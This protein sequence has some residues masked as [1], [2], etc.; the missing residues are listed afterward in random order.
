[1]KCIMKANVMDN[2]HRLLAMTDQGASRLENEQ[3]RQAV[4]S[5]IW[6]RLHKLMA[7][8]CVHSM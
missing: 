6:F 3:V 7:A 2:T 5:D 4:C 8:G 1:M